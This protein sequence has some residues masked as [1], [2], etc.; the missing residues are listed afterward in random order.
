M[1]FGS[2]GL[3]SIF[4]PNI[5]VLTMNMLINDQTSNRVAIH[6]V[7]KVKAFYATKGAIEDPGSLAPSA[8][9]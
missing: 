6:A 4:Q 3:F 7:V 9:R 1:P 2:S 5:H 8:R